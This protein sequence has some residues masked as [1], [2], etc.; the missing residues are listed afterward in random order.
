MRRKKMTGEYAEEYI[1]KQLGVLCPVT[2]EEVGF[3]FWLKRREWWQMPDRE[4]K[5]VSDH[6]S[7]ILKWSLLQ[8]PPA[9]PRNM[10]YASIWGWAKR[11]RRSRD[12]ATQ[13]GMEELHQ[14][15]CGSRWEMFC[16]KSSSWLVASGDHRVKEW[17]GQIKVLCRWAELSSWLLFEFKEKGGV[18]VHTCTHTHTHT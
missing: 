2:R 9:H 16:I 11:A 10:E 12:E 18:G 1:S 8:G 6:R 4:R 17:C 15:Q 13:R 3:R 5:R 7:H 14:R